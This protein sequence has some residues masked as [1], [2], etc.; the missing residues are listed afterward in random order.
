[1]N[2]ARLTLFLEFSVCMS[3]VLYIIFIKKQ[4]HLICLSQYYF[5]DKVYIWCHSQ[6]N[7]FQ[8]LVNSCIY[9]K[10]SRCWFYIYLPLTSFR[11]EYIYFLIYNIYIYRY[12]CN[13]ISLIKIIKLIRPKHPTLKRAGQ[14]ILPWRKAGQNILPWKKAVQNILP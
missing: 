9:I 3:W 4:S 13:H 2:R 7:I 11:P 8:K 5:E 14:Y 1:M 12:D 10:I 6:G